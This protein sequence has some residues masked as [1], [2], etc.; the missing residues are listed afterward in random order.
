MFLLSVLWLSAVSLGALA[1]EEI[2]RDLPA[3]S[4]FTFEGFEGR[5]YEIGKIQTPGGLIWQARCVCNTVEFSVSDRNSGD[6]QVVYGCR[7]YLPDGFPSEFTGE[8]K[9]MQEAGKWTQE[10]S[11]FPGVFPK[12]SWTV[13]VLGGDYAMQY[14]CGEALLSYE[15]AVRIL[16]RTPSIPE[17]I[18]DQLVSMANNMGL[19]PYELPYDTVIHEDCW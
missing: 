10:D 6:S 9:D 11:L 5:W 3:A 14:E 17:D 16:S 4:D 15:Y 18:K 12:V 13:L 8:L 2:C 7:E 1:Q 19:N